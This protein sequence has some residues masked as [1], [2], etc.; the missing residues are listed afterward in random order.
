MIYQANLAEPAAVSSARPGFVL[1]VDDEPFFA[2][3]ATEMLLHAGYLA[4]F[5]LDPKAALRE[6]EANPDIDLLL[7]DVVMRGMDGFTLAQKAQEIRPGIR[8]I[9]S[10]AHVELARSLI[11]AGDGRDAIIEKPFRQD[12]LIDA[13]KIALG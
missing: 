1:V 11:A 12:L 6:I 3:A 2:G 13:V 7:T 10:S 4:T 5:A 9:Y 8:V